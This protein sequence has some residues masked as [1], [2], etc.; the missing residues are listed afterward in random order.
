[1]FVGLWLATGSLTVSPSPPPP[2]PYRAARVLV[3]AS[4]TVIAAFLGMLLELE[5]YEPAFA[6][7]GETSDAAVA[8]LRPP[9]IVCIDCELPEAESDIFFARAEHHGAVIVAFGAPGREERVRA[10]AAERDIPYFVLPSDRATL[11]AALRLALDGNEEP[12]PTG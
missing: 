1:M 5:G 12:L 9:L 8:R 11:G 10:L 3:L 7:P 2:L 4:D 6:E